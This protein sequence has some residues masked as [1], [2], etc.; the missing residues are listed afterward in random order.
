M[1]LI[2]LTRGSETRGLVPPSSDILSGGRG[3]GTVG[4]TGGSQVFQF[5]L[6][7]HCMH[8]PPI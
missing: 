1:F 8:P 5:E 2:V 3:G 7:S 6:F 4:M